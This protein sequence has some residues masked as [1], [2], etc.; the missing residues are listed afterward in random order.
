MAEEPRQSGSL[1]RSVGNRERRLLPVCGR[2]DYVRQFGTED[3]N[4]SRD[5]ATREHEHYRGTKMVKTGEVRSVKPKA[6]E[7][8]E[9]EIRAAMGKAIRGLKRGAI[10]QK[11]ML[12]LANKK[13]WTVPK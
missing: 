9:P 3:S 5:W 10:L 11:I 1:I 7:A 8:T 6:G 4:T 12:A 2:A 13:S